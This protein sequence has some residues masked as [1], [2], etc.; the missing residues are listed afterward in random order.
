[1]MQQQW[2]IEA[3]GD[4]A[5]LT[6]TMQVARITVATENGDQITL[7]PEQLEPLVHRLDCLSYDLAFPEGRAAGTWDT[8]S[9]SGEDCSLTR[10][11]LRV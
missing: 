5:P 9:W 10:D 4:A 8:P 6:V 2:T 7:A 1:M 3:D 11:G